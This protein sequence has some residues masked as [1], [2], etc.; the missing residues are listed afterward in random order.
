MFELNTKELFEAVI[1]DIKVGNVPMVTSSPGMGKSDVARSI[2]KKYKLK[3]IDIRLSQ[4]EPVDLQ[5]FPDSVNGRMVFNTPEY[6]PLATDKI[7]EGYA[8]WLLHLD[9]FNS[10]QKQ[11]ESAAY[12]LI[13]DKQ[14]YL[15]DLHPKCA[16]MASG[17]LSTDRAIVNTLSTATTSRFTHYRLRVDNELW[18]NWA[19]ESGLDHRTISF[20][21]FK[22]DALHKFDPNTSEST[23]P[24][25]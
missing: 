18:I 10:G 4:C 13:L 14:V 6:L 17:N 16:I 3:M 24:C 1:S 9:E 23:F 19:N 15:Y 25:P 22:P 21:K 20:I 5:G 7:P 12:K 11:T 8:G 2:A